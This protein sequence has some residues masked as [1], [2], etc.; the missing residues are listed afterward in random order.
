MTRK[1]ESWWV[2]YFKNEG[3]TFR[4]DLVE[5]MGGDWVRNGKFKLVLKPNGKRKG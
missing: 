5:A 4:K 2:D 1:P 3:F